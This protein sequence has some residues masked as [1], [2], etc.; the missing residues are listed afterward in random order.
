MASYKQLFGRDDVFKGNQ[1]C[2]KTCHGFERVDKC[3]ILLRPAF[4]HLDDLL[5]VD[6]EKDG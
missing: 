4:G 6:D 2:G 5:V 3:D 1:R